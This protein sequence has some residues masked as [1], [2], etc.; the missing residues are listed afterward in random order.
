M[1][2]IPSCLH[3]A[4]QTTLLLLQFLPDLEKWEYAGE[5]DIDSKQAHIFR[6]QFRDG[7]QVWLH[8]CVQRNCCH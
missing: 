6:Q 1:T 3:L 7:E 4:E 8:L 2:S 5:V